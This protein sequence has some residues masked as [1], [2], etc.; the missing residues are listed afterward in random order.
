[1]CFC[2]YDKIGYENLN[3]KIM[4]KYLFTFLFFAPA[5]IYAEQI[6]IE[7]YEDARDNYFYSKLY[8]NNIG[9]SLYCG[10]SRPISVG[11]GRSLEHVYPADWIATEH[12]CENRNTCN[13]EKYKHAEGDLHNLWI[14]VKSI[15][16]SRSDE[17]YGE[18]VGERRF[19]YCQEFERTYSPNSILIEPRD[20]VK[21]NIARSLFYM[22]SEYGYSL[23]GMLLM[24]KRWNRLDPPG[25]HEHWRNQRIYE[26]QGTR[27]KFIDNYFLGNSL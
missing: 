11:G 22:H 3:Y 13:V 10:L 26:L 25:E 1:M 27:N 17:L 6:V 8:V 19:D 23:H 15:N 2:A 18:V 14:A 20:T 16:S 21:G 24:L 12:D 7:N 4:K 5:L 9:E